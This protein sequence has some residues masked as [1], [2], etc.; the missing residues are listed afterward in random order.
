MKNR[1]GVLP[2]AAFLLLLV[3][4]SAFAQLD[5]LKNR[6]RSK[7][8]EKPATQWKHGER[9]APLTAAGLDKF[10][11]D[12]KAELKYNAMS[13][14]ERQRIDEQRTRAAEEASRKK[15]QWKQCTKTALSVDEAMA[16]SQKLQQRMMELAQSGDQNAAEKASA[17]YQKMVLQRVEKKCGPEPKAE[18]AAGTTP[19]ADGRIKEW[20]GA[21]LMVRKDRGPDAAARIVLATPEEAKLLES[22]LP[23]L[24]QL[25]IQDGLVK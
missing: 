4:F 7:P 21:Y 11:T 14:A 12:W 3:P 22:R 2:L 16:M 13:N 9:P 23:Q 20:I 18:A 1:R 15:E 10:T 8:A 19:M 5:A 24:Q 25:A 6:I 17:E